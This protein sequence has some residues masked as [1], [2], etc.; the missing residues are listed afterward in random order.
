MGCISK[1]ISKVLSERLKKVIDSVISPEQSAYVKGKNIIDRPLI[2]N[3]TITWAKRSK[4]KIFLLKVDFEKA[5]D[6]LN[7]KF[8]FDTLEHMGFGKKWS[9]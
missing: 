7:W 9:G 8:L 5:F 6:N 1:V 4:K 2:V 3:E